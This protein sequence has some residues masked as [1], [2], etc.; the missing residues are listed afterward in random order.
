[1]SPRFTLHAFAIAIILAASAVASGQSK[2]EPSSGYR[3]DVVLYAP[4]PRFPL[5]AR[6]KLE[7]RSAVALLEVDPRTGNVTSARMLETTG[8]GVLDNAAL[9]AFRQGGSS[10]VWFP[11][12]G[13]QSTL[14]LHEELRNNVNA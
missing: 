1:M 5:Q 3:K 8:W 4:R 13:Y 14:A 2:D 10:R 12:F 7:A 11:T 6:F 9:D